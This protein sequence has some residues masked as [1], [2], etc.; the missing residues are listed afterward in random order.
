MSV[1]SGQD[2]RTGIRGSSPMSI[3]SLGVG[4]IAASETNFNPSVV[5]EEVAEELSASMF[6]TV[7][8]SDLVPVV[9]V[10][11]GGSTAA[12]ARE[13]AK[14]IKDENQ[15]LKMQIEQVKALH[16][17]AKSE[18]EFFQV[19][20]EDMN[21]KLTTSENELKQLQQQV[22]ELEN[23]NSALELQLQS[24]GDANFNERELS[25]QLKAIHEQHARQL[26]ERDQKLR[27]R[28]KVTTNNQQLQDQLAASQA[29]LAATQAELAMRK[30][31]S[32]Q[33]TV[34]LTAD[35]S[36][37]KS[38]L[39][40]AYQQ[41]SVLNTQLAH[42]YTELTV[43]RT[44]VQNLRSQQNTPSQQRSQS[45]SAAEV[46]KQSQQIADLVSD[47]R[48]LQLDLEYHQQ[49]LDQMI[50]EKQQMMREMKKVQGEIEEKNRQ[51][52]ER[53]QML[54]HREVDL[55]TMQA[56]KSPRGGTS[57]AGSEVDGTISA[58]RAEAAAKDSALIV[59][60][61]ELH[62]EKLLRDRLEQ[63]N[64]K[65][66]ERMQKLMMVVET[67][68]KENVTLERNLV[69]REQACDSKEQQLR[70]V[71][72]KAKQLQKVVKA[73]KGGQKSSKT[74]LDLGSP[75]QQ[76]LPPLE[77]SQRSVD[78]RSGMSTPRT[79][80]ERDPASPYGTR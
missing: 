77:R 63:K 31:I 67:M 16:E 37:E 68:R 15:K 12:H 50:E 45:E 13:Y 72:Q 35:S 51:I 19:K 53:D 69:S 42:L 52:E 36:E 73:G 7:L 23:T 41:I 66:M 48:H 5:A 28:E 4:T 75:Q 79:P 8:N 59:S 29:E 9:D 38:L 46:Q 10:T 17:S 56:M 76:A 11:P 47:I 61:Y 70:H 39:A 20:E 62:K 80:R 30:D 24:R 1:P 33:P 78:S 27:E 58:L 26:E 40:A 14:R 65:L 54:K 2:G 25:E 64:L 49:K 60:H 18:I 55:Q 71:T 21:T 3:G 32:T 57:T 74:I 43:A 6:D 44:E 34:E 22:R